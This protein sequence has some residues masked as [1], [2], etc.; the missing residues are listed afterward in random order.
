[1]EIFLLEPGKAVVF[2]VSAMGLIMHRKIEVGVSINSEDLNE[3]AKMFNKI[4]HRKKISD[5]GR[6]DLQELRDRLKKKHKALENALESLDSMLNDSQEEKVMMSGALNMLNEPEFKNVDKLKRILT[7]LEKD[8]IIKNAVPTN[9]DK[10][11]G[12][13]IGS[14]NILEDMKDLALVYAGYKNKDVIGKV[15][16]LGPIRMEYGKAAGAVESIREL[17]EDIVKKF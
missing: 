7:M 15:G 11:A 12:I 1:M 2:L 9:P 16:L 13:M 14:E 5:I 3:I 10:E 8:G 17:I 4:F 6:S